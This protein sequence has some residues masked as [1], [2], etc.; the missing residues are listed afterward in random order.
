M[1]ISQTL[2]VKVTKE[3]INNYIY[4]HRSSLIICTGFQRGR[5]KTINL[6]YCSPRDLDEETVAVKGSC[7]TVGP[8]ESLLLIQHVPF[9]VPIG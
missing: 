9:L 3:K 5:N 2:W 6:K 4:L 7:K 1:H 8:A